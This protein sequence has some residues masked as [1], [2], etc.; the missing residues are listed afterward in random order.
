MSTSKG[1][2]Q[3]YNGVVTV[4]KKHQVIVDASAFGEGQEHHALQPVLEKVDERYR[5]LG[6]DDQL[7]TKV[8]VTA[9]T[10][11]ANEANMAYLHENT[12]NG[13]IPDNQFRSRDPKFQDQKAK[14]P[15]RK[16]QNR[17]SPHLI[18]ANQ[19]DFDPV[20]KTCVCPSGEAMWLK[21]KGVDPAGHPKLFF[22]GRLTKCRACALKSTCMRNPASA[23]TREGHGRQVSFY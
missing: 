11:F 16:R 19:F 15:R 6:I 1:T 12:I 3:G 21:R 14:H 5:R 9:D 10:G 13:Y 7:L 4:D 18:P 17:K 20:N 2:L 23:N 22:E 8:I